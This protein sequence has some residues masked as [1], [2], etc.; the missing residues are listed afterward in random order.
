MNRKS[1]LANHASAIALA[2]ALAT[3]LWTTADAADVVLSGTVKSS[4]GQTMGGVTVSAKQE[5]ATLTTTV[6]S[7][8]AGAYYFPPHR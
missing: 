7:D 2:V 3:T 5:G 1:S 4:A 8:A 6:F